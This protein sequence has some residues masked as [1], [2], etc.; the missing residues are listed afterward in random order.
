MWGP[1]PDHARGPCR[2]RRRSGASTSWNVRRKR[3]A[4]WRRRTPSSRA[5]R[6]RGWPRP[7]RSPGPRSRTRCAETISSG[8]PRTQVGRHPALELHFCPLQRQWTLSPLDPLLAPRE[9]ARAPRGAGWVGRPPPGK[10]G[11]E[12]R[13][14]LGLGPLGSSCLQGCRKGRQRTGRREGGTSPKRAYQLKSVPYPL[15][16]P[17][18]LP[19]LASPASLYLISLELCIFAYLSLSLSP[20]HPPSRESQEPSGG[21]AGGEREPPR[22]GGG[23]HGGPHHRG[24]HRGTQVTG[25]GLGL[26]RGGAGP[27]GAGPKTSEGAGLPGGG[28][29]LFG[30]RLR[31]RPPDMH[32][33][34]HSAWRRRRLTGTQK[35][36]CGQP[37]QPLRKPSCRGSNKRTPTCGCRS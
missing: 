33:H 22:A 26:P 21:A 35:D 2:R 19:P 14:P 1:L 9:A 17:A 30:A 5:A 20:T 37:S 10:P 25:R 12:H 32:V 15:I 29:G 8:R 23:Q 13:Q 16:S 28:A 11:R 36:A 7:A 18:F 31:P 34:P 24:R 3:S 6:R 4:C 27:L